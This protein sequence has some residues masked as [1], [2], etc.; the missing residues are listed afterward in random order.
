[1]GGT[2]FLPYSFKR[3]YRDSYV[4]VEDYKQ[5]HSTGIE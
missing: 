4:E 5:V 3:L 1:M 2:L